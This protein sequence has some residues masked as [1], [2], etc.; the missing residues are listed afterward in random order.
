MLNQTRADSG[1]L[2][3]SQIFR[4]L[5]LERFYNLSPRPL[6]RIEPAFRIVSGGLLSRALHHPQPGHLRF[7]SNVKP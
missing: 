1:I 7:T 3:V 5:V 4:D 2:H 6:G